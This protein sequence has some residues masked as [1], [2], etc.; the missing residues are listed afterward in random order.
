MTTSRPLEAQATAEFGDVDEVRTRLHDIDKRIAHRR[1]SA[2]WWESIA[3]DLRYVVRGLVRSPAFTAMVVTTLAL[4]LGANGAIYSVLDRLFLQEPVGVVRPD[5]VHRLREDVASRTRGRVSRSTFTYGEFRDLRAALPATAVLDRP[6][7]LQ[8]PVGV[9]QPDQVHRLNEDVAT[10]TG[11]RRLRGTFTYG[12]L[13]D[14]RAALPAAAVVA[15]HYSSTVRLGRGADTPAKKVKAVWVLGD[16]FGVL[17]VRP[18]I[19]RFFTATESSLESFNQ[20]AVISERLW[21]ER[22]GGTNAALG[23]PLDVGAHRYTVIGVAPAGFRGVDLDV[24][25]IWLPANTYVS[26]IDRKPNAHYN[27]AW[28]ASVSVIARTVSAADAR[29]FEVTAAASLKQTG[30]VKD[31]TVKV[32]LGSVMEAVA[33]S[34][35]GDAGIGIAARIAGVTLIV[36]LIACA[37]VA[38]LLLARGLRRR[39]EI[40]IRLALG[41]SRRRLVL[42][43]LTESIAVALMAGAVALLF[44]TWA[45]GALRSALLPDTAWGEGVLSARVAAVVLASALTTG[46]LAGLVPALQVSNPDLARTLMVGGRTGSAQRSRTRATLPH[47]SQAALSVVLLAGAGLFLRSLGNVQGVDLGLDAR[48]LVYASVSSDEDESHD[49]ELGA[50]LPGVMARVRQM[51]GVEQVTMVN[52]IPMTMAVAAP[53]SVPGRDSLPKVNDDMPSMITVTPAFFSVTGMRLLAGRGFTDDDRE[54]APN[55]TI[56][57][58]TMAPNIWPGESAIGKCIVIGPRTEPCRVVVGVVRDAHR[59]KIVEPALMTY[60]LPMAQRKWKPTVLMARVEPNRA[61]AVAADTKAIL[62]KSL[63]AWAIPDVRTMDDVLAHELRP[64]RLG[65]A[66]FSAAALLALIVAA[67][68]VYSSIAYSISTRMHEMGIR[69]A[70]GA[71]TRNIVRLVVGEG[72]RVVLFGVAIG[73][74]VALAAG[75]SLSAF[76]YGT[77]PHDPVVLTMVAAVL[78]AVAVVASL[79]PA[80]RATHSD[81]TGGPEV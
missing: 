22:Y 9:V 49:G 26:W 57:N 6:F 36:L 29:A 3:Q 60:Y 53:V 74:V 37:N 13:R 38:N 69:I 62:V 66:L 68:G 79:V 17:G 51:P 42:Q 54:A 45:A 75:R 64:Y 48:R 55:V 71:R 14:L 12:E 81:P 70:L 25:D 10:R 21:K 32:E 56:V 67:V 19:G 27:N 4:G 8:E 58:E 18:L 47:A 44:T 5:Q 33:R 40:A 76:M 31:S 77:T 2:D 20:V 61:H 35:S 46:I 63:G 43:L 7:F 41:V 72:L 15:G 59:N 24:E 34:K 52:Y 65:A 73:T 28:N 30:Y 23:Q 1:Q 78:I 39:R 80:F 50:A 11:G 16:H